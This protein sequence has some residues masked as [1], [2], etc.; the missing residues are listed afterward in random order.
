MHFLV[1]NNGAT[2][3]MT[4]L[5]SG[6]VGIGTAT[7]AYKLDIITGV[8]GAVQIGDSGADNATKT[9]IIAA[10]SYDVDEEPVQLLNSINIA[11]VINTV[12]FGGGSTNFNSANQLQFRTSAAVNTLGG[13][14]RMGVFSDGSL[15]L[16]VMDNT[17]P[18]INLSGAMFISGGALFYK[19]FAGTITQLGAS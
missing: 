3:A 4:I 13:T 10:P 2:E 16:A 7:P 17:N 5:N 9:A 19:G 1:G 15:Q 6:N 14:T 11:G 12:N 8:G 18:T